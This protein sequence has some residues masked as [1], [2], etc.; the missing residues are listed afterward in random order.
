MRCRAHSIGSL[1]LPPFLASFLDHQQPY[2]VRLGA[3]ARARLLGLSSPSGGNEFQ[4]S[5]A[6]GS[7]DS[8]SHFLGG[9]EVRLLAGHDGKLY[10][11]NGYWE[12]RP[13]PE[14]PQGA[15]ILILDEAGARWRVDRSF[16]ERL[17]NG[18]PRDLAI[19]ALRE[20]SFRADGI[21][22]RLPSP[23]SLLVASAIPLEKIETFPETQ[24]QYRP[25]GV[26]HARASARF[27]SAK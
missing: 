9:T 20:V 15:Q 18:R 5:F 25:L 13:G 7:P 14:G 8:A 3:R 4:R 6:A 1:H 10:A 12:D 26:T 19:S 16:D 2:P 27:T 17:P 11:G 23:V 22:A 24:L 21:G